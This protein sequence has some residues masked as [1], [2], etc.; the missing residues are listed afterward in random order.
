MDDP[1]REVM[2]LRNDDGTDE[3]MQD[4]MLRRRLEREY[5]V[6][7]V[8]QILRP[9]IDQTSAVSLR[10]LDWTVVNW[11]KRQSVA[12]TSIN[13]EITDLNTAYKTTLGFWKRRLFDPFRR[14]TRVRVCLHGTQ[15]GSFETT[16]GQAN[17]ALFAHKTG[18]FR[19]ALMHY[20]EIETH[21]NTTLRNA[22][23]AREQLRRSNAHPKPVYKRGEL[24]RE[25]SKGCIAY[26]SPV[27]VIFRGT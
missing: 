2:F 18:L 6:D 3:R 26:D 5:T 1:V 7:L 23:R 10:V 8:Q 17:F 12:T 9:L 19:Y 15:Q 11:T 24:M 14:A 22:R 16:L 13:G 25:R 27:Y 4:R 20:K 21:M